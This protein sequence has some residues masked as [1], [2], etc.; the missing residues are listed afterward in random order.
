MTK[1][2][3]FKEW[4]DDYVRDNI[5]KL[6]ATRT[7]YFHIVQVHPVVQGIVQTHKVI[8][9]QEFETKRMADLYIESYNEG[10]Q[11]FCTQEGMDV[12]RIAVYL[13]CVNDETGELV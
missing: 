9:E 6:K 3:S 12:E 1:T 10:T 4:T 11:E 13:G 7:K 2:K 8:R 5:H